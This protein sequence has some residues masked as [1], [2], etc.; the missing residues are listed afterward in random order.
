MQRSSAL[1]AVV[2]VLMATAITW[3]G[4]ALD[5][6]GFEAYWRERKLPPIE[7]R[8]TDAHGGDE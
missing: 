8:G 1:R 3:T 5:E 4:R 7:E 6:S 2:T